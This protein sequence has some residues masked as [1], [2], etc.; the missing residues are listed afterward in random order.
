MKLSY[1]NLSSFF[2]RTWWLFYLLFFLLIGFLIYLL[3]WNTNSSDAIARLDNLSERI[4]QCD[5]DRINRHTGIINNTVNCDEEIK[6]GGQGFTRSRHELGST[7][8][9]VKI[10]YDMREVPDQIQVFYEGNL[11]AGTTGLVSG[12]NSVEWYYQAGKRKASFCVVEMS[13]PNEGTVW[14][15]SVGCPGNNNVL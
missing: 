3:L 10:F 13:A 14:A 8:G 6:S 12:E 9:T 11:V 1:P 5:Q 7:S 4:T 15:Y 2:F